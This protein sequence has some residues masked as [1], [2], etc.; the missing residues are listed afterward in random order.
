MTDSD[1]Q[2]PQPELLSIDDACP[3]EEGGPIARIGFNYQDEIAVGFFIEMLEDADLIRIHCETH[4]DIALVYC[5]SDGNQVRVEYVQVKAS[6]QDKHWSLADVCKLV[7]GS[8]TSIVERSL[9]RDRLKEASSFRLVTL[10]QVSNDLKPLTFRPSSP[11]RTLAADQLTGIVEELRKRFPKLLS[12]KGNSVEFWVDNCH[13]DESF[14]EPTVR[15]SNLLRLIKLSQSHGRMLLVEQAE[16]ILEDLRNWAKS[17]ASAKWIPDREKKIISKQQIQ[18]WWEARRKAIE[19]GATN[20]GGNLVRKLKDAGCSE[21]VINMAREMRLDYLAEVKSPNYLEEGGSAR[22]MRQVMSK[23][24][25]LQANYI[26]GALAETPKEFHAGC[27]T[28]M[29]LLGVPKIAGAEDQSP[30]LKG[31]MYDIADRCLLRF[32]RDP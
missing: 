12:P 3:S 23:V 2:V 18:A 19:D 29:D 7:N 30:L 6:E 27:L 14:D 26:A 31:C 11:G 28:G 22:L 20:S 5:S 10:R 24:S 16:L 32:T 1:I 13:W 15:K 25:T 9:G 8:G 21:A 4:D 17:A